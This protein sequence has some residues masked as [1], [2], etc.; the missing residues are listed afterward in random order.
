MKII[1]VGTHIMTK[2]LAKIIVTLGP[3]TNTEQHLRKMKDKD[4]DFVRVNMS[5]SSLKDLEYFISLSKR[6]GIPFII[7]T[8]GSQVRTGNLERALIH[9]KANDVVEIY[10]ADIPGNRKQLCLRPGYVVEQLEVGDL[11][12]VDFD[13]L[14]LRVADVSSASKGYV[15]AKTISGGRIGRNKAVVIDPVFEKKFQLPPLSPK[16][17]QAIELGL[18]AGIDHIAVS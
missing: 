14:I 6:V 10:A 16:D 2:R 12:Y 11:I 3:A 7:D 8:E 4:V 15:T 17:Y 5:H 9:F 18:N 13:T 1:E